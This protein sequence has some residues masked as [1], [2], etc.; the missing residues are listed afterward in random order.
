MNIFVIEKNK[1]LK[2]FLKV[3]TNYCRKVRSYEMKKK[4]EELWSGETKY[5][6][7]IISEI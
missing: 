3:G 4:E 2:I 6:E 5:F 1:H 7:E